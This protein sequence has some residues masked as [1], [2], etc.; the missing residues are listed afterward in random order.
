[1]FSTV[2]A[3]DNVVPYRVYGLCIKFG[4]LAYLKFICLNKLWLIRYIKSINLIKFKYR[5]DIEISAYESEYV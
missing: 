4:L 3:F 5:E 2:T 1:M